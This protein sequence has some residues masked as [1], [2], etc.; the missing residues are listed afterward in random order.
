MSIGAPFASKNIL[1][2]SLWEYNP[3]LTLFPDLTLMA[4]LFV[5]NKTQKSTAADTK[6]CRDTFCGT[7]TVKQVTDQFIRETVLMHSCNLISRHI[8]CCTDI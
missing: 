6:T 2:S 8:T 7:F 5:I 1:I 4:V 3:I